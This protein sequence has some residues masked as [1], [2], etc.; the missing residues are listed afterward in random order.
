[1]KYTDI[2]RLSKDDYFRDSLWVIEKMGLHNL[3]V[4]KQDYCPR[5]IQHFFATLEFDAREEIGFT[6]M[7]MEV[8]RHSTITRF[9]KLL[10][11]PFDGT[12]SP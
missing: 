6:W 1:M 2:E 7:T 5:L 11:Y 10:G 8:R 9:G 3:M 12:H 4:F